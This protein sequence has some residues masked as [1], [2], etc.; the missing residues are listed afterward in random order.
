MLIVTAMDFPR[1]SEK[2]FGRLV[3]LDAAWDSL[4]PPVTAC[5]CHGLPY[6]V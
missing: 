5:C 1:P 6:A 3:L 2:V 4:W